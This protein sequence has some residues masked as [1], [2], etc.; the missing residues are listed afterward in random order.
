M[1]ELLVPYLRYPLTNQDSFNERP[2]L[3]PKVG[4]L[5]FIARTSSCSSIE[6]K[7]P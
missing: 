3:V 2:N 6:H 1:T 4:L 7:R 5:Y